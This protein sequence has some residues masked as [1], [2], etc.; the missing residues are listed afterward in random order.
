[1]QIMHNRFHPY[2]I[3]FVFFLFHSFHAHSRSIAGIAIKT[4]QRAMKPNPSTTIY[5]SSMARTPKLHKNIYHY[6]YNHVHSMCQCNRHTVQAVHY[7]P[8]HHGKKDVAKKRNK[9]PGWVEG[10]YV[11]AGNTLIRL[12]KPFTTS[13]R[14]NGW[15]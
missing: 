10:K 11:T 1:M 3:H 2:S 4:A 6:V 7:V 8:R 15:C 5:A 9:K 14:V 13:W 12:K